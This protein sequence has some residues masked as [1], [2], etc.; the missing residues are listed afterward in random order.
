M[1]LLVTG[2]TGF[3]GRAVCRLAVA[4]GHDVTSVARSGRPDPQHRGPWADEVDWVAADVLAP[5]RW[6]DHLAG[7]DA[8]VHC[9]GIARERPREGATFE[10][11]NG[12]AAVVAALE[13]E[14]AGAD[15][16]VFV[17]SSRSPPLVRDAYVDAK[18]RAEAAIADL[19]V[20]SAV[21]RPGP[22]YGPD[23]PHF[24]GVVAAAFR[25]VDRRE[26]LAR[27]FEADRPLSVETVGRATY[28][29][30]LGE[31]PEAMLD[32][33]AMYDHYG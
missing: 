5:H 18:R 27:Q 28:D 14:R 1:D 6:R 33:M 20:E 12:D 17:S 19:D 3:L 21:V 11:V 7:V 29:A 13:S 32:A 22:V 24:P 30:A 4:D 2:G 9:V 16:F 23:Q 26:S 25:A 8:V 10:R 31:A 15:R